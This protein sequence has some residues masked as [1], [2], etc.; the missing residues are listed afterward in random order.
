MVKVQLAR[1]TNYRGRQLEKLE[2]SVARFEHSLN[3]PALEEKVLAYRSPGKNRFLRTGGLG[4]AEVLRALRAGPATRRSGRHRIIDLHLELDRSDGGG[5]Y[6]YTYPSDPVIYT[7]QS[8]LDRYGPAWM[9]SHLAHEY[10]HKA[11]FKH[12]RERKP[13][14]CHTVPYAFGEIVYEVCV[15]EFGDETPPDEEP[16][17]LVGKARSALQRIFDLFT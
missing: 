12:S 13:H 6:G 4:N 9:A 7:Y 11:G 5:V 10:A 16:D 8:F 1:S 15:E 3:S 14:R 2:E 17:G